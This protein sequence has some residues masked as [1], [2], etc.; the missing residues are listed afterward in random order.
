MAP[1]ELVA[2]V[3]DEDHR[4]ESGEAAGEVVEEL[5]RRIVGPMDI[6]DDQQQGSILGGDSEQRD[7]R[8]EQPQLSLGGITDALDR[9]VAGEL[10]EELSERAGG[11]AEALREDVE[12]LGV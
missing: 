8:F 7:D 2:A 1:V 6:L 12:V 3:G 11:R 9:V 4:R 5:Q 10:R